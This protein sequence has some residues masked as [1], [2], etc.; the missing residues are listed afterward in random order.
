MSQLRTSTLQYI[1]RTAA[2][3][4]KDTCTIERN[5]ESTDNKYGSK[6]QEWIVVAADVP[7]RVNTLNRS[8]RSLAEELAS[9]EVMLDSYQLEI[10]HDVEIDRDYRVTVNGETYFVTRIESQLTDTVFKQILMTRRR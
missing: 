4:Y 8:N 10:A 9:Q 6:R 1:R 3:F 5:G 7:C 2:A